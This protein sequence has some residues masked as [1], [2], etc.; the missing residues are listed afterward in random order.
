VDGFF[1]GPMSEDEREGGM[2][3]SHHSCDPHIG[4]RRGDP[5]STIQHCGDKRPP[6]LGGLDIGPST[7]RIAQS[8]F[9][10]LV[11]MLSHA[12][13]EM[14]RCCCRSIQPR[15]WCVTS[16]GRRPLGLRYTGCT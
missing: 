8:G 13:E 2:I 1:I 6:E 16:E 14:K 7:C 9:R 11:M 12:R 15:A 5:L 4:V 3:F 10:G